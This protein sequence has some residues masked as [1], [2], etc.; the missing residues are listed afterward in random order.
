M[1]DRTDLRSV[2]VNGLDIAYRRVGEGPPLVFLHGAGDDSRVWQPQLAALADEFTVIAWDEPGSGR[3]SDLP[4]G[5]G[6]REYAGC[7][8]GLI[9]ALGLAPVHLLG[10]SWGGVIAVQTYHDHPHA[11][12][13]LLLADTYAGWKGSLDAEELRTRVAGVRQLLAAPTGPGDALT[14]GLFAGDTPTEYT[15]LLADLAAG[16]RRNTLAAQL[17]IIAEADLREMLPPI[18]VPTLLIWGERDVRSPLRVARQFEDAIPG[19]TLVV[20]PECGHL[21]NLEQPDVFNDA[22]RRHCRA[23]PTR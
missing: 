8:A 5:F 1:A 14:P 11:I 7:L 10:L 19:A 3:S 18:A 23:H 6:L 22:V 9:D 13:S 15:A 12:R 21:S 2:R 20:L 17:A 16:V 4:A